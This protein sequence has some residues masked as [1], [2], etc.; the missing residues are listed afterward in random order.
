MWTIDQANVRDLTFQEMTPDEVLYDFD[1]PRIFTFKVG[2]ELYFACWSDEDSGEQRTRY[3]V[4]LTT[5]GEIEHLKRGVFSLDRI[6]NKRF[7]WCVDRD[8]KNKVL[9]VTSLSGGYACVPDGFKPEKGTLLWDHLEPVLIKHE[10]ERQKSQAVAEVVRRMTDTYTSPTE[11]ANAQRKAEIRSKFFH[12]MGNNLVKF[13][14][15]QFQQVH[16]VVQVAEK[17]AVYTVAI[18]GSAPKLQNPQ[19]VRDYPRAVA[20]SAT[21][22]LH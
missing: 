13:A 18:S 4:V 12:V 21:R 16:D 2:A 14:Y 6:L 22:A 9:E 10:A 19:Q 17:V 8:F 1:G 20:Q 3:L 11:S 5:A 7:L 15:Q